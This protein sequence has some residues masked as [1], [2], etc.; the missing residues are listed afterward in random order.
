[1]CSCM[2]YDEDAFTV[3]S[4]NDRQVSWGT[5]IAVVLAGLVDGIGNGPVRG[6]LGHMLAAHGFVKGRAAARWRG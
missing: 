3:L 2:S 6:L 1:M 5:L 4:L